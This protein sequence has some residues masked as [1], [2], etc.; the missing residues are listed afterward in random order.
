[1]GTIDGEEY[2]QDE[3]PCLASF[4]IPSGHDVRKGAMYEV[5]AVALW[6]IWSMDMVSDSDSDSEY[7]IGS[8]SHG[9]ITE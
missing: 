6:S 2:M 7:N 9:N 5:V 3:C 4:G 1:M 8:A